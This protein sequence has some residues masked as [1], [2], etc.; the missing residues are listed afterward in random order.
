MTA[1]SSHGI[2]RA[3]DAVVVV[4]DDLTGAADAAIHFIPAAGEMLL[5]DMERPVPEVIQAGI[6]GFALNTASRNLGS[7]EAVRM[8]T[9][10]TEF[11]SS[12]PLRLIYKKMDS[13][14]RGRPGLEIETLRKDLG[15]ACAFVAPAYPEQG[16]TTR[17]AIHLVHGIPVAEGEAGK[18]P[19]TPVT[20]SNL[21]EL[22]ADQAGVMTSHVY[23]KDLDQGIEEVYRKIGG[24]M[25]QGVRVITFDAVQREHLDMVARLGLERFSGTLLAGSAGLAL[26]AAALIN[27][28]SLRTQPSLPLCRSLLFACGSASRVLHQQADRLVSQGG[29]GEVKIGPDSLT[30]ADRWKTLNKEAQEAWTK[31]DLLIRISPKPM[32]VPAVDTDELLSRLAALVMGL[33]EHKAVDGIFFS[34]GDTARKV[35]SETN[36]RA[37]RIKGQACPGM[38]WGVAEGGSLN[39]VITVTKAGAFGREEDLVQLYRILKGAA[40]THG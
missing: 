34:G 35:L 13:Q 28:G 32:S 14:L 36:A 15:L 22:I 5:L 25:K 23:L 24:F 11:L 27:K 6:S 39:G 26:S 9:R 20:R 38:A 33:L 2:P 3:G 12:L 10:A 17:D 40:D 8:V 21:P 30:D 29:C 16:R 7:R 31:G 18:D 4:A 19:V 1:N 37:I